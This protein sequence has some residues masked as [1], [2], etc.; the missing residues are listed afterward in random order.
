MLSDNEFNP[1][2][3]ERLRQQA[4]KRARAER[5]ELRRA[6][7]DAIVGGLRR[8]HSAYAAWRARRAAIAELQGL[9]DG[10]L[11][12]LGIRRGE[13]DSVVAGWASDASRRVRGAD[14]LEAADS[15][16]PLT[17]EQKRLVKE[18]WHDIVPIADDAAE[19]FYKRL[20]EIDSSTRALFRADRMPEQRRKLVQ[21]LAIVVQGIDNLDALIST[22]EELGRRHAGYGVSDGHYDSVAAALLWTFEQ[23]LGRAWTPAAAAAWTEL[24]MLLAG[25]MRNAARDAAVV[26]PMAA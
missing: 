3:Y 6:A 20:F 17:A 1:D 5:S 24:Y 25:V 18:T 26:K 21:T 22:V 10:A 13:I 12:D 11:K 4:I 16:G 8:L 2:D 7:F 9:D 19:L 14:P 23:G 15:S